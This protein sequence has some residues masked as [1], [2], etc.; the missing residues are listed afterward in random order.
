MV[1]EK[2]GCFIYIS[3]NNKFMGKVKVPWESGRKFEKSLYSLLFQGLFQKKNDNKHGAR[4]DAWNTRKFKSERQAHGNYWFYFRIVDRML[5]THTRFSKKHSSE[6]FLL[7]PN[8]FKIFYDRF[9]AP[10]S[11]FL[12][13]F[14]ILEILRKILWNTK[15][16]MFT[17]F[18][19][20]VLSY[21][22]LFFFISVDLYW[23]LKCN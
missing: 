17:F 7:F 4:V 23:M 2:V 6:H 13:F 8:W 15:C 9:H 1:G 12:Q 11:C 5:Y 3:V 16:P 19:I 20:N 21:S 22:T 18:T 10:R 14:T